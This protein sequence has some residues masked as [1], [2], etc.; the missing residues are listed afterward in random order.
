MSAWS[1]QRNRLPEART[2]AGV[3]RIGR[4]V[5][6]VG[7]HNGTS[8][9]NTLYRAQVLDPLAGPEIADLDAE[10]GDGVSGLAGG[11]WIYRVAA[12]YRDN[13][14]NN[15]NGESIPGEVLNVQL[16]D[17]A[18]KIK[19]KLLWSEVNGANG[20]RI[21]RSPAANQ[22]V[23]ALQLV[24]EIDCGATTLC[25]CGSN[26]NQCQYWDNGAATD[27]AQTP[28][29]PG[30]LGVWHALT[31]SSLNVL[32]EAHATVAAPNLSTAG[33]WFLYAFGGRDQTGA[34]LNSYEYAT[35]TVAGD[36][37]QTV[38]AWTS[39]T[40]NGERLSSARAE[41]G[42]FVVTQ[43]DG[44]VVGPGEVWIYIGAG[45]TTSGNLSRNLD[46]NLVGPSGS[47]GTLTY[48]DTGDWPPYHAGYGYG[49]A[50]NKLFMF[51]GKDG[52][53]ST[54]GISALLCATAGCLPDI[55]QT[56]KWNAL[57][58]GNNTRLQIYSGSTQES[59]FFF[60]V[61]GHDG[62]NA[63]NTSE[64]TVQ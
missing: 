6:L 59:A 13:D 29:P 14:P 18:E 7:G 34:Y 10:L 4:F 16:P 53:A 11:Q 35:V 21:Y 17:R 43:E 41:L 50:N 62:T 49:A 12:T 2:W 22:S 46:S 42:A 45:R 8:A 61:G 19:L 28:L 24:T 58:P 39:V 57:G 54:G 9:T 31:G 63:L 37:S 25:N 20:Y 55:Q 27:S 32:R 5:Y 15:P 40:A 23:D 33:Q 47:L 60:L 51:G 30:S 26:P 36:G 44:T 56:G 48:L 3:A 1:L 52:S 64:Q 38:S